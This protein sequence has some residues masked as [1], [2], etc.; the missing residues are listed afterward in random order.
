M[1]CKMDAR[2]TGVAVASVSS[3]AY[4]FCATLLA[5]SPALLF[6]LTKD[7]FHGVDIT[8]IASYPV[9][10]GSAILGFLE[11][12]IAAYIIGWLFAIIYNAFIKTSE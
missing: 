1:K 5:V 4:I 2:I 11:I 7:M 12:I 6:K 10:L 9:P 8:K 3:I